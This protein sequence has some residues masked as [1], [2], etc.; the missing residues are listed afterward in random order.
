MLARGRGGPPFSAVLG[1]MLVAAR[2]LGER[3]LPPPP[4][5]HVPHG[6]ALMLLRSLPLTA[7][8]LALLAAPIRAGDKPW[9]SDDILALKTVSDPEVSPD[10]RWV[11]YVVSELNDEKN[12]YQTDVWLVP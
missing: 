12:D 8:A 1:R 10:G 4:R 9:T 7:A 11:A 2:S 5:P 3:W 6:G